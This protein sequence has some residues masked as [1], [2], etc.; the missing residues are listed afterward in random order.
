[1]RT[2]NFLVKMALGVAIGVATWGASGQ[3]KI[4][5]GF[6]LPYTGTTGSPVMRWARLPP[7]ANTR[8]P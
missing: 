4:K 7:N 8:R 5:V 2:M 6:M 3:Q 1:M